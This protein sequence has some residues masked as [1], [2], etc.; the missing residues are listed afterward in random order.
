MRPFFMAGLASAPR[1]LTWV[2]SKT[3]EPSGEPTSACMCGWL[4]MTQ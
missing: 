4:P 1:L 2:A 3:I